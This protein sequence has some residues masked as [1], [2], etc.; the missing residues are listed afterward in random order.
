MNERRPGTPEFNKYHMRINEDYLENGNYSPEDVNDILERMLDDEFCDII[1]NIVDGEYDG[2]RP[3]FEYA[4]DAIYPV[5]NETLP[6]LIKRLRDMYGFEEHM[7]LN[8]IDVSGVTDMKELFYESFRPSRYR[9][10]L[11]I[12]VSR[13][14]VS[15]VV[16]TRYMFSYST[17]NGD[18]SDWKL[19]SVDDCSYMFLYSAFNGDLSGWDVSNV[20]DTKHMISKCPLQKHREFWPKGYEQF[21]SNI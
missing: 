13:W 20:S 11:N 15:N 8:W 1:D 10:D 18:V 17:F 3:S 6:I 9:S 21:T 12:D 14:D 4:R 5:Y 16:N 19:D 2:E 7:N